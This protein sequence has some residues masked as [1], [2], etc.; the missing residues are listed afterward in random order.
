RSPRTTPGAYG[1]EGREGRG[2][3][4]GNPPQQNASRTPGRSEAPSALER[5]RQAAKKDRQL[6]FTALLHHIYN[7]ETLRRAYFSLKKEAAAGVDGETWRHYGESLEDNLRDLSER[8]KR[9]AYRAKPVRRVYIPKADGR[10]RPLGVTALEDKIAQRATV[11]VLNAIYETDFLGFS[12]GFRPGRSQHQTLDALYTGL[13]TKKV[14][15]VLDLDIKGFFDGI[16]HEWLVKFIEHRVA[17]RRVV[18]LIQKWLHAGVLEDG[19][20]IRVEEGTPQG[21]S[22]SPLLANVYLH[23][24]FDLWVQ[25]WGRKWAHGDMII[26]RFADDIVLGFQVKSDA[27]QFRAELT[28]RMRKFNLELH[29]Q[30]TRLLEFGPFAI[31]NRQRRGEGKPETFNFLGFTHICVKKRSNGM[32]TVLRQT[33]RKRLQAK[34]HEV[35]AELKRRMHDPVP[36][37]GQWL[38]AVVRGHIRYYGVPM[39]QPALWMFRFQ[40]GRLWHRAL[41][42][43]S[44]NGRVLWDRMRRL[45]NR[46]LP[47][48]TVCHPYPLRRMGVIT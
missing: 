37:Q 17:D 31:N 7:L 32:Y 16:S 25:A 20:R 40:V 44:Q 38:Q 46:W 14:N 33:I 39:N 12:Y 11:E 41:S 4:K 5:V 30:K 22:A 10:Q 8:L 47:R 6:R 19:K 48:P 23:Y 9:G 45:I 43:R 3:A 29:P 27:D 28:E 2:L 13:L 24:V 21:G 1:A 26:V 15:W 36:D 42:R 35:K 18:R 34:L